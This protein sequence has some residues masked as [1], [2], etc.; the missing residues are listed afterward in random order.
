VVDG[1]GVVLLPRA[2]NGTSSMV[3]LER[4]VGKTSVVSGIAAD[5]AALLPKRSS[6]SA[7]M[8][9]APTLPRLV[10]TEKMLDAI[11]AIRR[12]TNRRLTLVGIVVNK[13]RHTNTHQFRIEG[14]DTAYPDLVWRTVVLDRAAMYQAQG[15]SVQV[16]CCW[17][18]G[19]EL[20]ET[21][22]QFVER[23]LSAGPARRTGKEQ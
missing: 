21:Y 1:I 19:T 20:S 8:R 7:P 16:R 10:G 22:P 15:A 11:R 2:K 13:A 18:T 3:T 12:P 9:S 4:C 14:L 17:S 5:V 23:L 6:P